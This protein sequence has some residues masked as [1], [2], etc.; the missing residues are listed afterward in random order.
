MCYCWTKA[1]LVNNLARYVE[2]QKAQ[3]V[4]TKY[5]FETTTSRPKCSFDQTAIAPQLDKIPRHLIRQNPP[6]SVDHAS[7]RFRCET[8]NK[9]IFF[10]PPKFKLEVLFLQN[11]RLKIEEKKQKAGWG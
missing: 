5:D 6:Y 2:A 9:S 11:H 1:P 4:F 8:R 7:K 10:L 3:K